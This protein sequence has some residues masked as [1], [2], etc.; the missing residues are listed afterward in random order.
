MAMLCCAADHG[1]Y[2]EEVTIGEEELDMCEK[3]SQPLTGSYIAQPSESQV[4]PGASEMRGG[5][6]RQRGGASEV[7]GG[8]GRQR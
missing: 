5:E 2:K 4:R 1:L 7:R 6:G 8:E 3:E